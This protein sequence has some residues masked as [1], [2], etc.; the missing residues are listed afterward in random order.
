M[1]FY[2]NYYNNS[3]YHIGGTK[4][5]SNKVNRVIVNFDLNN[6]IFITFNLIIC[7]IFTFHIYIRYDVQRIIFERVGDFTQTYIFSLWSTFVLFALILTAI[8]VK[9]RDSSNLF[10][11]YFL[12]MFVILDIKLFFW[13]KDLTIVF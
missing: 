7:L 8:L 3:T 9:V 4:M 6:R 13:K 1:F 11:R 5:I 2:L 12:A 10:Y